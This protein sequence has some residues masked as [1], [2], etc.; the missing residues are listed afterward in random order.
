M[1]D[2]TGYNNVGGF[3]AYYTCTYD[4][5]RHC[6]DPVK[7]FEGQQ[8]ISY[9]THELRVY[10]PQEKRLRAIAGIF[11]DNVEIKTQDEWV[12]L[13]TPELGFA[14]NAPIAAARNINPNT[15][16]PG[17]AF[18]NDITRT[19]DQ[20]ALF[21]EVDFDIIPD[22]LTLTLG[23]RWYDLEIDYWGSSNFA[24]GIFMGSIDSVVEGPGGRDY[25]STYGHSTEPLK[26]DDF[27]PKITLSYAASDD[28]LFYGTYSEGFR[29]GGF[30]RGGGAPSFNPEFPTVPVTYDSDQVTNYEL[31]W[32][33]ILFDGLL[34]FNGAVYY[35]EWTDMQVA[36]FDPINVS[37]LTFIDNSADSEIR[38]IE[39][40]V[41]WV[42]TD[43]LTLFSAFSYNDTELVSANS[44]VIE[45]APVGS[46]L[47]L[48]P[49][50]QG[51]IRAR[52][53]WQSGEFDTYLTGAILYAS[54][55]YSSLIAEDRREQS[56]YTIA[57]AAFGVTRNSWGAE[58]FIENLTD[59]RAELF[60]NV[61]DD[62]P[63]ITTNRPRTLGLRLYYD[64]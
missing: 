5:V 41:A 8:D 49:K 18:F 32:K 21:G 38:G 19:H 61:Q 53:D 43:N 7:G 14:P 24:N 57:D 45:L 50:F 60:F 6:L 47:A 3:I 39:G 17:V 27:I 9:Q 54:K 11:L 40:D 63:R 62:V 31:G 34:Q 58:L 4:A 10:T 42:A 55:S 46:Q 1:V 29:P 26:Q 48:T 56:S 28:L 12:Y 30:N 44:E 35:V 33:T 51:N 2:Y 23:L 64:F 15:R 36:R 52:Y 25:D 59:E 13:A 20:L 16:P 22:T 37:I